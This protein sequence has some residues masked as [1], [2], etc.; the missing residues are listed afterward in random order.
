MEFHSIDKNKR[1]DNNLKASNKG[2]FN[3]KIASTPLMLQRKAER[4]AMF[5]GIIQR[6]KGGKSTSLSNPAEKKMEALEEPLRMPGDIKALESSVDP[7]YPISGLTFEVNAHKDNM[8][9]HAWFAIKHHGKQIVEAGS[10]LS[11]FPSSRSGAHYEYLEYNYH[12]EFAKKI[13]SREYPMT[14]CQLKAVLKSL[15]EWKI[16]DVEYRLMGNNCMD[17]VRRTMKEQM[18]IKPP[19]AGIVPTPR[20]FIR[21]NRLRNTLMSISRVLRIL[22]K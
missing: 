7:E 12:D 17:F 10:G 2:I 1:T 13:H 21:A 3:E 14:S 11:P 8:P 9:G 16:G 20:G 5:G 19:Y 6:D 4:D 18:G 22:K 15:T